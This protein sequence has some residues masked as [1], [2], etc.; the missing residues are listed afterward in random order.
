M[1]INEDTTGCEGGERELDLGSSIMHTCIHS[2]D[3]R[4]LSLQVS[5]FSTLSG[6]FLFTPTALPSLAIAFLLNH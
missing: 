2:E 4:E 1:R 5:S 6:V 3:S